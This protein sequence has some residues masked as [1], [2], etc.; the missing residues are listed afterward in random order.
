[1]I[2]A[3]ARDT[4]TSLSTT[5]RLSIDGIVRCYT[6]EP[7]MPFR[8]PGAAHHA[9]PDG[10][11]VVVLYQ[12]PHQR[13]TVPLLINV[14]GHSW[15]EIHPGNTPRE[16]QGCILVGLKRITDA[17]FPSRAIFAEI[18]GDVGAA[19]ARHERVRIQIHCERPPQP[20]EQPE[21]T[22]A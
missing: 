20:P 11:Y 13:M 10:E 16:T 22:A 19:I 5:G 12:S 1:M 3:L 4:F 6:L 18:L 17:V 15:I 7:P 9:I 2:L 14:P 8:A 21:R